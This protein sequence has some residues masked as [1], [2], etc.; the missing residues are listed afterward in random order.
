M[1]KAA[2]MIRD[3]SR[4]DLD[5]LRDLFA[6]ANDAPYDL[7]A[8]AAEKCFGDGIAGAPALRL[9]ERD[10]TIA[11]AAVTSGKWLR[12]L[13]VDRD[14]RRSGIGSALLRDA[15]ALGAR[16]I[17]AEPGNYFTPGVWENDSAS[18]SFLRAH[19]YREAAATTNLDVGLSGIEA[20]AGV[21][22]ASHADAD[23]VLAFIEREFGRIWRFEAAKAFER[24]LPPLYISEEHQRVTGFAAHDLNNRGLGFFGPAGV[25]K[26]ARGR[27]TGCLLVLAS[28]ADLR[29]LGYTRAV[30]PWT[31]ALGFYG[32][33]CGAKP[34]HRFV[35][36]AKAQ[37]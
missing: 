19:G 6:R 17:A 37:P 14:A 13:A 15:E 3:G 21:R 24:D 29:R 5:A 2:R 20:P 9:F 35:A 28:L 18:Q 12:V 4:A 30:I 1:L 22:R 7:A 31:D 11:G 32:R 8:V 36:F 33:C 34:A 10:G 26:A 25:E 16:V 27:G 23:R